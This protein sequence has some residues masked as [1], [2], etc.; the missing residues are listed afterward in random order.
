MQSAKLARAKPGAS[1]QKYLDIS[2]IR[3][4]CVI[5][6]DGTLRAVLTV[7]SINF[8]LKSEEEQNAIISAY[9]QFLNALD[10][11]LQIVINSRRLDI[12]PYLE[13][14]KKAE[15]TQ[16][17]ELLR[18]QIRGYIEYIQELV[19]IGEI[20][21]KHFY[22]VVPYSPFSD[23]KKGFFARLRELLMPGMWIRLK[24]EKFRNYRK[25]LFMRVDHVISLLSSIGLKAIPLD[26]QALIELYYNLYNPVTSEKEK[27]VDIS[28]TRIEEI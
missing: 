28:K 24:E 7:S 8:A 19:Q 1:T 25:E 12:T 6:K 11:P 20:M 9:M 15:R 21:T 18:M 10:F 23:K 2:E 14:L 4:D 26:T 17:N 22:V 5:L 27:L 3:D 13:K 16:T